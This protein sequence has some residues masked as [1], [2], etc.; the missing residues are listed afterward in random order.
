[1]AERSANEFAFSLWVK[2]RGYAEKTG[3]LEPV[4]V[5]IRRFPPRL[6]LPRLVGIEVRFNHQLDVI[7]R[8]CDAI[9]RVA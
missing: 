3:T 2:N 9:G 4:M 1:M 8:A 7:H 6:S 5:I